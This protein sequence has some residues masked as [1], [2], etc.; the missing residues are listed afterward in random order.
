[1]EEDEVSSGFVPGYLGV[2]DAVSLKAFFDCYE[3]LES[4]MSVWG[5]VLVL[6]SK[7]LSTAEQMFIIKS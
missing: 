4:R 6:R 1:M 5:D 7:Y 2:K 3:S